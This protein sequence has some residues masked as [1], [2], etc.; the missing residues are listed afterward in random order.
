MRVELALEILPENRKFFVEIILTR[1]ALPRY[2]VPKSDQRGWI[3]LCYAWNNRQE[4]AG[5]GA[6]PLLLV[7][8]AR[9]EPLQQ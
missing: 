3:G 2:R 5:T 4:E 7:E 6:F 9:G 8:L 1:G